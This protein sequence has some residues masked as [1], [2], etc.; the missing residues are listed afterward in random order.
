MIQ[1]DELIAKAMKSKNQPLL[2]TY[3]LMKTEFV[4]A[5]KNGTVINEAAEIKILNKMVAQHKDSIA[6]Y[7]AAGR[8]EL[9]FRESYELEV[10]KSFLPAEVSEEEITKYA[11]E[12]IAETKADHALSMKDMKPILEKVKAKYPTVEGKLVSTL[13][14]AQI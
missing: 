8:T 2:N 10:I 6:Q 13:L 11:N 9:A 7:E 14:K 5:E 12:V 3:R 4:N 1:F